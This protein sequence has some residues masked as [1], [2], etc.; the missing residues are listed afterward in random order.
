[1]E[2]RFLGV[3]RGNDSLYRAEL[4]REEI[5]GIVKRDDHEDLTELFQYYNFKKMNRGSVPCLVLMMGF[6]AFFLYSYMVFGP[7]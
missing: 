5:Y 7:E 3:A 4:E 1:M 6:L 2:P